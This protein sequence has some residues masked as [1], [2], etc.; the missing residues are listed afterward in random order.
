LKPLKGFADTILRRA[1]LPSPVSTKREGD[2]RNK[3]WY[4]GVYVENER[5]RYISGP[6]FSC[7]SG[8]TCIFSGG[9]RPVRSLFSILNHFS[10]ATLGELQAAPKKQVGDLIIIGGHESKEDDGIILDE[11]AKRVNRRAGHLLIVTIATQ[12]PE[13]VAATYTRL[14]KERGCH[15]CTDSEVV[16]FK[17]PEHQHFNAVKRHL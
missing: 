1:S 6:H 12:H 16:Q 13:E 10:A 8:R 11:I 15:E 4:E 3:C 9:L 14:F 2:C 5:W 17:I 7:F